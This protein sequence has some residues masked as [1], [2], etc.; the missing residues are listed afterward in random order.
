M[1][2]LL[3]MILTVVGGFL[4]AATVGSAMNWPDA[5]SVFAVAIMGACILLQLKKKDE[6]ENEE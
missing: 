1:G 5:G 3:S 4:A 6:T 2:V